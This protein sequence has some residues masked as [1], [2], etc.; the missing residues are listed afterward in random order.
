MDVLPSLD[1]AA[2]LAASRTDLVTFL[3]R[4]SMRNMQVNIFS[5][6]LHAMQGARM[7]DQL[8]RAEMA[9]KWDE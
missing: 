4:L 5:S 1:V 2:S 3:L 9:G 8:A 6:F 7:S